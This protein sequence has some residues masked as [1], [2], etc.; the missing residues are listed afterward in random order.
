MNRYRIAGLLFAF[1]LLAFGAVQ[2]GAQGTIT[3]ESLYER[4][5]RT[6]ARLAVIETALAPTPTRTPRP[7][8]TPAPTRRPTATPRPGSILRVG[9]ADF[10]REYS[11]YTGMTI[12]VSG[13]VE[14][15]DKDTVE[16]YVPGWFTYFVCNLSSG[17]KNLPLALKNR[18]PVVLRG[19]SAY[20]E[21]N[22]VFLRNC[23]FI[24]PTHV[25]LTHLYGTR[26]ASTAT[27]RSIGATATI[28]TQN[29]RRA[30]RATQEAARSTRRAATATA[31]ARMTA[32]AQSRPTATPRPAAT[33]IPLDSDYREKVNLILIG[34]GKGWDVGSALLTIGNAFTRAGA[35][36]T[37]LLND[38]WRVEVALA[39][40]VLQG[41]YDEARNL[42]PPGNLRSF[43]NLMVEGLSYCDLAADQIIKGVDELDGDAIEDAVGLVELCTAMLQRAAADPNW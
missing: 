35:D 6:D 17:E 33:S 29:T 14:K 41:Q 3:L 11:M 18:Q 30:E 22:T 36:P 24:L 9:V 13:K 10:Y 34:D 31:R 12:E 38:T 23:T 43:H 26:V 37:L 5:N 19:S 21:S 4:M 25:E 7:D 42:K 39:A 28:R 40:A 2:V 15:K 27:A 1:V 32:N 8:P 20:K 16:L